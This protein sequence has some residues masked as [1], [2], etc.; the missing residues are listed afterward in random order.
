MYKLARRYIFI[1]LVIIPFFSLLINSVG[2]AQALADSNNTTNTTSTVNCDKGV[3]ITL[4]DEIRTKQN[5]KA[6]TCVSDIGFAMYS[7]IFIN[8]LIPLLLFAAL[9]LIIWS[10]VQYMTSG[11][12][13]EA[14]K[15]AKVRIMGIVIGAI[16]FILSNLILNIVSPKILK[17]PPAEAPKAVTN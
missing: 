10:G 11:I 7:K 13:A 1:L 3:L 6:G 4:T 8:Q 15:A 16:F 2:T 9:I 14:Q 5:I 17:P 12:N